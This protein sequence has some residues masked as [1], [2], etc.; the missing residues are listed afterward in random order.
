M[1]WLISFLNV[2]QTLRRTMRWLL[3]LQKKYQ[4]TEVTEKKTYTVLGKEVTFS[5]ELLPGDM[6]FI[7][8]INGELSNSAKYFSSFANVSQE[9]SSSLTGK[10]G[11]TQ[12][13]KW[14]PWQY[15]QRIVIAQQVADYK[16]KLL[17]HLAEKPKRSKVTQFIAN[18]RS[19]QEFKPFIGKLCDK[20]VVE[21]LHLKNNGEQYLHKM[22]LDVAIS[23]S[24]LPKTLNSLSELPPNGAITRY[25][26]AMEIDVKT[27]RMKKQL[28]KWLLEE[29]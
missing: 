28:G 12:N 26:K 20:E 25:L 2:G 21:P 24:N 23:S 7:A 22:L 1:S 16:R 17:G 15:S 5:F 13:C 14:R 11:E 19:R 9:E 4:Q 8:F 6:K 3:D 18:K 27:G 10:F 29:G